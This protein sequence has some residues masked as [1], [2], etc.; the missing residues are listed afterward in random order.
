MAAKQVATKGKS[1][2]PLEAPKHGQTKHGQANSHAAKAHPKP[3]TQPA[4]KP[5]GAKA[6]SA[7]TAPSAKIPVSKTSTGK[8]STD[9][10]SVGKTSSG[11]TGASKPAAVKGKTIPIHA[12]SKPSP[13]KPVAVKA[14]TAAAAK[15]VKAAK[16]V[17]PAATAKVV[18]IKPAPVAHGIAHAP[19]TV[20]AAHGKPAA[21]LAKPV[22][23]AAVGPAMPKAAPTPL[24]SP[25]PFV[26]PRPAPT[27][28][29]AAAATRPAHTP[30]TVTT[31]PRDVIDKVALARQLE[32][33]QLEAKKKSST[34]RHGFKVG[35]YVVYPSHGVG[36]IVA[37][38]EQVVA[39][40]ALE[41]F[42]INFEQEKMTLRVPTAK[43]AAVGMRKLAEDGIVRRAMDTLR[44]RARIKRT[45]WSRRAQEYE[46]KINSGDLVSISEVVRDLYRAETQPEQSYSER[47]LFEAALDR[48]SREI[49]A[50]EKLDE[51]G[52]VQKITEV[53]SKSA[54]GRATK[55]TEDAATA[56]AAAAS[57]EERAA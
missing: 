31:L 10:S 11:R 37:I 33:K 35:E 34:Q 19:H 42:V 6:L 39:G 56:A 12:T 3:G 43:L 44:G 29:H 52:A 30:A 45:M 8:T 24:V 26:S 51:R 53:L 21:A 50:V 5:A 38:E 57:S 55:A 23:V 40:H 2:T 18:A 27:G 15:P 17:S 13:A 1:A 4:N 28:T 47:Q 16:G 25:R 54:K 22:A 41:L 32:A 46:N 49:A 48:M 20:A 7:K 9:K 36:K 14:K